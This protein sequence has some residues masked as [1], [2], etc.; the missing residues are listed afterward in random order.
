M[1]VT[2]DYST[3][4]VLAA[5]AIIACGPG[6]SAF[7]RYPTAATAFDRT[8]SDPKALAIA[9]RVV[10]AAGGIDHWN[11]AKQLKWTESV[12]IEDKVALT[13]DE[14]WDRWN[15]RHY[16]R[17]HSAADIESSVGTSKNPTQSVRE[18][19]G[20]VVVMRKL[21]EDSAAAFVDSGH[22]LQNLGGPETE[23]AVAQA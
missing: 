15:G 14:A 7:A 19:A 10:A 5:M 12:T 17:L 13:F 6:R 18:G 4:V 16:G 2:I 21:Y 23:R 22:Q 9:D 20:D 11:Q 8:G 3:R 1:R